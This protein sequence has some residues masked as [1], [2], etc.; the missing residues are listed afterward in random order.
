[1]N[2]NGYEAL[3]LLMLQCQPSSRN[4]SLGILNALMAWGTFD[5]KVSLLAQITRLE[6]GFKEYDKIFQQPTGEEM[7]FAILIRCVTGQLRMHLMEDS[8]YE[9]LREMILQ[10][11]RA[12]MLWLWVPALHPRAL[13]PAM[14]Q[15]QWRSTA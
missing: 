4:R 2:A 6:D 12:N 5:M 1:M 14:A 11:D 13:M 9:A 10:F 8:S 7:M 3:R 15:F